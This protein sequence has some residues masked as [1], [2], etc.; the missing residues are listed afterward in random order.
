MRNVIRRLMGRPVQL[1]PKQEEKM[2]RAYARADRMVAEREAEAAKARA[3]YEAFVTS[4]GLPVQPRPDVAA[5]PVNLRE[6]G[7]VLKRSFEGFKDAVGETFDDRRDVLDPGDANLNR[8]PAEVDDEAE[9]TRISAAERAE[10]DRARAPFEAP[11]P[12]AIAFT[13]FVTTGREQLEHVVAALQSSGLAAHPERVFGVYRVPDRHDLGRKQEGKAVVEWEIAHA[14]GALD[15]ARNGV[16]T[17]GFKRSDH[18]AARR[19]GEPS[20]LDEDVAGER[21]SRARVNPEDCFGLHRLLNVRGRSTEESTDW[22]PVVE[23]VLLFARP[24]DA[25]TAAQRAMTAEAPLALGPPPFHV[26]VLDWEAVAAW[27]SPHRYGPQRV[28][29]PLPHLPSTWRELIEAY[30]CVVGVR[31]EDTYGV[32]VTRTA[33]RSLADLSM[34]SWSKNL[35]GDRKVMHVAE[36]VVIAYRDSAAYEQ[37]RGRWRAYQEQVLRARLDR[38]TGARPPIEVDD[39]PRQSFLSEVFDMFDPFS[40]VPTVP[41]I[42]NR[43]QR[44]SLGPYCGELED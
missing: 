22:I 4:Q 12:P 28:P 34:A 9:R 15:P 21:V 1:S 38:L 20:V 26:E 36:H 27:V 17:A 6:I 24:L 39:H 30:L 10:R 42:F 25:I 18:W 14:P 2:A 35:H 7:A 19:P 11:A 16:L 41:Q 3:E 33:D 43:N 13:R 44:P 37:G 31:S 8:P 5:A 40:A 32:Q 29:S 23:G